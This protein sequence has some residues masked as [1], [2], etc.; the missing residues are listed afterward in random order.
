MQRPELSDWMRTRDAAR[1]DALWQRAD[2]VRRQHVGDAVHLRGLVEL[3]NYCGRLCGYCGLRAD[4]DAVPRYRMTADE[5]VGAAREAVRLGF[6]TVVLQTG[7]DFGLTT[8]WVAGL[9]RRIKTETP[10]AVTLSLGERRERELAAWRAAGAD[11]Y[12]LR[13]ETS[14][15][16]LFDAIHPPRR[17]QISDRIALLGTLRELGYE[18]GSGVMIGIPGQS[19]EDLAEDIALLAEL[20]VDMVGVGPYI[21]DPA[22]PLGRGAG[23]ALLAPDAQVPNDAAMTHKVMAL[24]RLVCPQAN[25]PATTALATTGGLEAQLAALQRGANVIMPNLTPAE[26]RLSYRIYPDKACFYDRTE[27][28]VATLRARLAAIGRGIGVGRGDSPKRAARGGDAMQSVSG[29]AR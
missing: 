1:L 20:D 8:E 26:Y 10:L 21:P 25:I 3:S 11:R 12:L 23:P 13:F 28:S 22:T 9:V 7:E 19:Y 27:A 4:N 6:G 5:V 18:V 2:A 29:R 14:N 16:R 17:G 15:R 24:T